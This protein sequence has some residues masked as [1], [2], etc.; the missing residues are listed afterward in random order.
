MGEP[1]GRGWLADFVIRLWQEK[2][3]GTACGILVAILVF[4]AV[5]AES[6]A[7][8]P[9]Q[10]IHLADIMQGASARYLLGTDHL[11]RDLLSRIL[12]ELASP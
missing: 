8:Y 3:L 10:E 7:P 9:Y 4:V 6:L 1:R 11:G 2:P 12:M 5:L